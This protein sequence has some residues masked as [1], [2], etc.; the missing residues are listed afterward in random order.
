[1]NPPKVTPNKFIESDQAS[2][3]VLRVGSKAKENNSVLLNDAFDFIK[4]NYNCPDSEKVGKGPG[5]CSNGS[6]TNPLELLDSD[7][8][9][10]TLAEKD[11]ING[12]TQLGYHYI[13][14]FLRGKSHD[15]M[16]VRAIKIQEN[17]DKAFQKAFLPKEMTVYSGLGRSGTDAIK[18]MK[19]DLF[20]YTGY[21]S[22]S[23]SLDTSALFASTTE[24]RILEIRL[25]KN[26]P[27][28]DLNDQK[29]SANPEEDEVLINTGTI[30]KR[31]GIRT[32]EHKVSSYKNP[33]K[34][35][36]ET[37]Q[38][39]PRKEIKKIWENDFSGNAI[40][41][42][43]SYLSEVTEFMKLNYN[44]LDSEKVGSGKGSCGG[45]KV[46]N[47]E[48]KFDVPTLPNGEIDAIYM[49]PFAEPR[50]YKEKENEILLDRGMSYEVIGT[51][52]KDKYNIIKVRATSNKKY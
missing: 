34:F 45:G 24:P 4:L 51:Y 21:I 18:N 17:L 9:Y 20:S 35:I 25:P 22:T 2:I 52:K 10:F 36:I 41:Q 15:D 28:I 40:K 11:A 1:M 31:I 29:I 27:A 48:P 23:K 16:P 8:N 14:D 6:N 3:T 5:S 12:Y 38:A 7:K 43:S 33:Q 39:L 50:S 26:A 42:Y 46:E 37:W 44:C 13:N 49:V 30:F 19:N 32:E 47:D